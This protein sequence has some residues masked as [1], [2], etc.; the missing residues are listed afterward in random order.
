MNVKAI[1]HQSSQTDAL[2]LIEGPFH[3]PMFGAFYAVGQSVTEPQNVAC[4]AVLL[5][6]GFVVV[7]GI[8]DLAT[9]RG[10]ALRLD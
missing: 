1:Y 2:L 10:C 5:F 7:T 4:L 3:V 6:M 8:G 9:R